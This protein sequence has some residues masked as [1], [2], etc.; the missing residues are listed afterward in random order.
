MCIFIYREVKMIKIEIELS[1][2]DYNSLID[3]YL[4]L[5]IEKLQQTDNPV[6]LLISNGMPA[7]MAK[8]I[9]KTLPQEKKDKLA[10][11][12]INIYK[13]KISRT[14]EETA[15]RQNIQVKIGDIQAKVV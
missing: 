6:A 7:S 12:L 1:D 9:L 15:D 8:M 5:M 4:P 13:D 3:Q 2:L 11:D 14:I 10:A